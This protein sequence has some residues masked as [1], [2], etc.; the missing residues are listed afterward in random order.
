MNLI[1]LEPGEI[2]DQRVRLTAARLTHIRKVL[3]AGVGDRLKVGVLDGPR[4]HGVITA[5]TDSD[6]ELEL[7]CNDA[8]PP[9]LPLTVLLALPR[10]K[11]ARR[12]CRTIAELGIER[13]VLL[14]SYRVEKAYWQSPLLAPEK[15]RQYFI[16]GLQ[17]AG[18]TV[19]P[20]WDIEK[21]F[22]PFVEDRLP[23]LLNGKRGL[24][25]HPNTARP[26]P[27]AETQP[28]VLAIGPEGGFI[29]Y[30]VEKLEQAGLQT[31]SLGER[32]LKVETA[33][34]TL[35]AKLFA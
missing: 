20:A 5:L 7:Q 23:Q 30:E 1:L 9:K 27:S 15:I 28:T 4:G 31:V 11:A 19:L 8:P 24:I 35:V 12:L 26:C 21:R 32:I 22:K 14:N 17:Q 25:A 29:P 18:D 3:R 16:E 33:L 2:H 10:P 34:P 6:V 13:L